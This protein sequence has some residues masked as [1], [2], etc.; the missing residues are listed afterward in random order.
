MR[1][2]YKPEG[3]FM[4]F[5]MGVWEPWSFKREPTTSSV[6]GSEMHCK[7]GAQL[8]SYLTASDHSTVGTLLSTDS[9]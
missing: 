3:Q 8:T 9:S 5:L 7:L 1:L 6:V 2:G 4:K